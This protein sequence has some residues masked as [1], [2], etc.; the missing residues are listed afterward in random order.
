MIESIISALIYIVLIAVAVYL[1]FWVLEAIAGVGVPPKVQQ[2]IWVVVVLIAILLLVRIL[3]PRLADL[4]IPS[5]YAAKGPACESIKNQAQCE[6]KPGCIWA[7]PGQSSKLK[8]MK[9]KATPRT[10][11][12]IPAP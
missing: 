2:L 1:V 3:L 4:A 7:S 10:G 5:A 12:L 6:A 11:V 8:C 9:G